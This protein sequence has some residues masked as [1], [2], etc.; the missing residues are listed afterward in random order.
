MNLPKAFLSI[1]LT[2]SNLPCSYKLEITQVHSKNEILMENLKKQDQSSANH[3]SL[4][5]FL[6]NIK[7]RELYFFMLFLLQIKKVVA[8]SK[9]GHGIIFNLYITKD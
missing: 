9:N 5:E 2:V 7:T 4:R 1:V 8:Q 6:S 3:A